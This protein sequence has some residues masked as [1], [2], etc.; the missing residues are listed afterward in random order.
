MKL[1]ALIVDDEPPA[2]KR[3][4]HLLADE[5]RV[6]IA[7]EAGN[8]LDAVGL[9]E[10]KKPDL[11]FLDIQMPKMTGFEVLDALRGKRPSVVFTTAYDQYA[12]KAFEVKALDYLLKPFDRE[13]LHDA[14][15]RAVQR[16]D[17][18]SNVDD[19]IDELLRE[20]RG[21]YLQRVLIRMN[22]RQF[23]IAISDVIR[24][25][26]AEKYVKLVTAKES[27]LHRESIQ[28]LEKKL[29]SREF[30][31][32]HRSHII[33][34]SEIKELAPWTRGELVILLKNGSRVPIGRSYREN[35]MG[36]IS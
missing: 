32:V 22:N 24:I 12:I 6:E 19:R 33:R 18:R 31:R 34:L 10:E 9:I 28:A 36:K 16:R 1:R 25:E 7:G 3:L 15:D 2:R 13:R 23:L 30:V 8:G 35:L 20:M 26:A 11:V 21:D 29:D 4:R 27:F 5:P 14:V 17:E